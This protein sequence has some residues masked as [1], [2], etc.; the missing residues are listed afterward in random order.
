MSVSSFGSARETPVTCLRARGRAA[1]SSALP[2]ESVAMPHMGHVTLEGHEVED[3]RSNV[4][5]SDDTRHSL[6][7]Y[8]VSSEEEAC[9]GDRDARREEQSGQTDHEAGC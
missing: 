7:V 6:C 2:A 3:A 8:R 9:D 5:P 1:T 4:C